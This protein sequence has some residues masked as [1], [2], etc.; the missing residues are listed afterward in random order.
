MDSGPFVSYMKDIDGRMLY[1]NR[2]L[3]ERLGMGRE[4]MLGKTD[5]ELWPSHLATAFREHDLSVLQTGKLTVSLEKTE[6]GHGEYTTAAGPLM[7]FRV[8][9]LISAQREADGS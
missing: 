7:I 3:A 8:P 9:A 6:D 4:H 1:Y 2:P 5:A